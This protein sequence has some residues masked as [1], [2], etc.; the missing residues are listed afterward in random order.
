MNDD[1]YVSLLDW[2]QQGLLA[3]ALGQHI[4]VYN[5][6]TSKARIYV[7]AVCYRV[8]TCAAV[9]NFAFDLQPFKLAAYETEGIS[10]RSVAWSQSGAYLSVGL[11]NGKV[12]HLPTAPA[13]S[14]QLNSTHDSTVLTF[15]KA[16]I[17][18]I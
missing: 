3:V 12:S 4:Y 6:V 13:Q 8:Y 10:I 5:T 11:E 17:V 14:V 18:N 16:Q 15:C 9:Q 7:Y 1:F 2:S